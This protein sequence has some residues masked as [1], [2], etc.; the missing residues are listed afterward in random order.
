MRELEVSRLPVDELY[1]TILGL[2]GVEEE[3]K[4]A[5]DAG[6][7]NP[8]FPKGPRCEA[9]RLATGHVMR[10]GPAG[11]SAELPNF[12]QVTG[13]ILV[14]DDRNG[15]RQG[16]AQ[17]AGFAAIITKESTLTLGTVHESGRHH[18]RVADSGFR[19][20]GSII[21]IDATTEVD[22][23][24][25]LLRDE[26]REIKTGNV[27]IKWSPSAIGRRPRI[28]SVKLTS[29]LP[30]FL[31][32]EHSNKRK[33][34]KIPS[35]AVDIDSFR[36]TGEKKV[37]SEND[38]SGS[39]HPV[40]IFADIT[41]DELYDAY[42]RHAEDYQRSEGDFEEDKTERERGIG[43]TGLWWSLDQCESYA[44][45]SILEDEPGTTDPYLSH[46]L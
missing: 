41:N 15:L 29:L 23:Q 39:R 11:N 33:K 20:S 6:V 16:I 34:K 40:E 36:T 19:K 10:L 46:E 22:I 18:Q 38:V 43:K 32:G 1:N 9:R 7:I 30:P 17:F 24:S 5:P 27:M 28:S 4:G 45:L 25:P 3:N 2:L 21:K 13:P 14:I 37:T 44:D 42:E 8:G 12:Q 31:Q 35:E 26:K